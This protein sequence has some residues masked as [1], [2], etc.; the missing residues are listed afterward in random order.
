MKKVRID[1]IS[2]WNR[3][4]TFLWIS[5]SSS[6]DA[7]RFKTNN[8][9]GSLIEVRKRKLGSS[10]LVIFSISFVIKR[11]H[12]RSPYAMSDFSA[13][14]SSRKHEQPTVAVEVTTV[15]QR[16]N[17]MRSNFSDGLIFLVQWFIRFP[18]MDNTGDIIHVREA[19]LQHYPSKCVNLKHTLFSFTSAYILHDSVGLKRTSSRAIWLGSSKW[20]KI[21]FLCCVSPTLVKWRRGYLWSAL[22]I[23][24]C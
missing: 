8:F 16:A 17:E 14:R 15:N 5:M 4:G 24:I 22:I 13:S 23:A 10:D 18:S 21:R 12:F 11:S 19:E 1:W 9:L 6:P 2:K 7:T 3:N 20:I